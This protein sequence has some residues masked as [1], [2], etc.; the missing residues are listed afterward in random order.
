[1]REYEK[2]IAGEMY[3]A[4]DPE[5]TE[6]RLRARKLLTQINQSVEDIRTG[7]RFELVKDLLGAVGKNVWLQPPFFCDYG[8]NIT[9]G[10]SVFLNFN[11][12]ILDV[13]KVT[14]GSFVFMAPN[15]QIYT[16]GHPLDW[17]ERR[18]VE[19]GKPITIGDD[20]WIGGSAI[21]CPGVTI[22]SKSVIGAGAVVTKDVPNGVV[23]AG[24]P[25]RVLK[26]LQ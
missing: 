15:V 1:M 18:K 21:I 6:M 3:N 19:F 20:V 16:A 12:V 7:P 2:M 23:V 25:A 14:V 13:A 9:F 22:G 8:K 10:D 24:N 5:L 17:Q 26:Q 11:C 4:M